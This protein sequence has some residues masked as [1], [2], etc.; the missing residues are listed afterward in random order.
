MKRISEAEPTTPLED[1]LDDVNGKKR[2]DALLVL[3]LPGTAS[4]EEI[5]KRYR[6]LARESHPDHGGSAKRMAEINAAWSTL[7][8]S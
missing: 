5:K 8:V 2:I 7:E 1:S 4:D 3:G 6:K